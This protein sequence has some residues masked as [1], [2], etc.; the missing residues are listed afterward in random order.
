VL[1]G[2]SDQGGLDAWEN[3]ILLGK[4]KAKKPFGD[5]GVMGVAYRPNINMDPEEID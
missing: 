3:K 5:L 2:V 1:L 4:C